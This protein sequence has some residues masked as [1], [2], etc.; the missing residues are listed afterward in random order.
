MH[1]T[2]LSYLSFVFFL[3]LTTTLQAQSPH[4]SWSAQS[5]IYEVNLRQYSLSGSVNEFAKSLPRL[6]SMGVEVL[7]FMPINPIGVEERKMTPA[8]LG[9]YYAVKDYTAFNP[10]F[11]TLADFKAVVK[12][13]HAMGFKV[14]IDWVANHSS[15]DNHWMKAHPDFY[16]RDSAGKT[17]S[18]FDWSDV[19]KL[20]YANRE[21]RDSM[22]AAMQ[23]WLKS[24]DIDGFRCDVAEEVPVDFWKECISQLRKTKYVFMLAEGDKPGLHE[25]GFDATYTWQIMSA[26]ADLYAGKKTL[27]QFDSLLNENIRRYPA[28]VYRMY[29]TSNHDENSWA[30][31]EFEKYGAAYKTF[32]VFTQTFYQSVPLIYSGQ[33]ME[34]HK[35]LKFFVKDTIGWNGHYPMAGFYK[36]LLDLRKTNPALASD[37]SYNRLKSSDDNAIFAYT[38][39]KNGRKILVILNLSP[40]AQHAG[41]NGVGGTVRNVFSGKQEKLPA[42]AS[43]E[44]GPWDYRVYEYK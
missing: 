16:T 9:S 35:R 8:D 44:L 41:I 36:T 24:T 30:G 14:I 31:T 42:A 17:V 33:E 29:F 34:N 37:A 20:N 4:P 39:A 3:L 10:E 5:N 2:A 13:A 40:R 25:A 43:F 15:P 32:A 19:R 22:I 27:G 21:L 6:K 28:G 7:W 18:P 12:K 1:K 26:M 38:R 23:F 11:G